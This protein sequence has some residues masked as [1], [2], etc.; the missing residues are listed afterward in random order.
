MVW[1]AE[2]DGAG[3][4]VP[5]RYREKSFVN[6]LQWAIGLEIF[7]LAEDPWRVFFTTD[8][9]NGAPFTAYPEPFR[10]LM[11]ADYRQSRMAR[12]NQE[13]LAS[14]LLPELKREFSLQDIAI[15]TRAAPA[16][17]LG[18]SD[19]GHLRPGAI[20]DIAAYRPQAEKGALFT[21][22]AWLWK[23]GQLVVH[24][25]EVIARP[26]GRALTVDPDYDRRIE[27]EVNAY[28]DRF[29]SLSLDNFCVFDVAFGR[30]D[31]ERFAML[32]IA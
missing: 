22:A 21:E 29:Y 31:R 20:A 1:E 7:L 18:P 2:C 23:N 32:D 13:A 28:F 16:R 24:N 17:L 6:T 25:G 5:Y 19:R 11:D 3:G 15:M 9:P 27:R 26:W 4:V 10:L 30:D 14:T 8:H 12:L